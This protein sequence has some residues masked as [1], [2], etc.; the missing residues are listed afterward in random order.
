[1]ARRSHDD[2]GRRDFGSIRERGEG[3]SRRYQARYVG[4]NL[5]RYAKTFTTRAD[6]DGWL[7]AAE[8]DMHL[9]VWEPPGAVK[10]KAATARI[11]FQDYAADWLAHRDLK[12]R[13]RAEY[14]QILDAYLLP[15]WGT[16]ALRSIDA[17]AV[18]DW[19][20]TLDKATPT[21]RSHVY[22]LMRTIMA[23]A[24][25]DGVIPSNPVHVRG[26][27]TV[28]RASRTEPATLSELETIVGNIDTIPATKDAHRPERDTGRNYGLMVLAAAWC[29][30]RFG[31]LTELRRKDIVIGPEAADEV[32]RGTI[33]VRR[34]V[35]R[36]DGEFRVGDPKSDAGKRDVAIPP[37]LIPAVEDHLRDVVAPGADALLWP[38]DNGGHLAPATFYRH[39]YRAR[40]AAGRDDLRFHDLRHTG[41]VLAAQTGATLAELM[42]RLGHSTPAAAMRYQHAAKDR[43]AEIARLLSELASGK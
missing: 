42:E 22:G 12:P 9:G 28:K 8:R 39:F 15:A 16:R 5:Q 32:R 41:A 18:R 3:R 19:Y 13:S 7:I 37:H 10:K 21:R 30:L 38:A 29:A 23:T 43:G 14:Q 24:A 26:A 35:V 17:D 40:T 33:R 34:A 36:V 2:E 31:E 25:G 11:T 27:G 20:R 6:A 4:A 1:M